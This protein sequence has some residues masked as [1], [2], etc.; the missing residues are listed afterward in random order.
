MWVIRCF[1]TRLPCVILLVIALSVSVGL[2]AGPPA[3]STEKDVRMAERWDCLAA[4]VGEKL[5][6]SARAYVRPRDPKV[7]EPAELIVSI[8]NLTDRVV[9]IPS[10]FED[11]V[12]RSGNG[13]FVPFTESGD[14][15]LHPTIVTMLPTATLARPG[16]AAIIRVPITKYFDLSHPGTY[17]LLAG[18]WM[19]VPN[20]QSR[21]VAAPRVDFTVRMDA[22]AERVK[23]RSDGAV[24]SGEYPK[25]G[26]F[27]ARWDFGVA[28]AQQGHDGINIQAT[29][30]PVCTRGDG[31]VVSLV[32]VPP[33]R[34]TAGDQGDIMPTTGMAARD[35]QILLRDEAERPVG[36]PKT[37]TPDDR[38]TLRRA[39]RPGE[40]AG[41]AFR[42][43]EMFEL[44]PGKNYRAIVVLPGSTKSEPTLAAGPIGFRACE[45]E[46]P[47]V[48]R[49]HFG[50]SRIWERFQRMGQNHA[51]AASVVLSWDKWEELVSLKVSARGLSDETRTWLEDVPELGKLVVLAC[52]DDR[53]LSSA[54][55]QVD[56]RYARWHRHSNKL[57]ADVDAGGE[58]DSSITAEFP[59]ALCYPLR[60]GRRFTV[61]CAVNLKGDLNRV[62]PSRPMTF[63]I[64]PDQNIVVEDSRP[65]L[66][67]PV[68]FG[69]R[70][71]ELMRFAGRAFEGLQL[72]VDADDPGRAGS[73]A[74][75]L[76]AHLR[77]RCPATLLIRK[78]RGDS[79]YEVLVRDPTGRPVSMTEKGRHFFD[80]GTML[81]VQGL[82]PGESI[83]ATL[84]LDELFEMKTPGEYTILASLP[85]I[86]DVD[87]V[88]TA[89]P[90]TIRI[91]GTP[92]G[93]KE[94]P[95]N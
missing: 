9:I 80:S 16:C 20:S 76:R 19:A 32:N 75:T 86:G 49:P 47:G 90:I 33:P 1:R 65:G 83:D 70:W 81:D 59:V 84:R 61:M 30:S 56:W 10:R 95:T 93:P 85:V 63:S 48:T 35:Y 39:L 64:T 22:E 44:I 24:A 26:S 14:A 57:S 71:D 7:G 50:S 42:L 46:I 88:L 52:E 5:G 58:L 51:T 78:W 54:N 45:P 29:M 55:S 43:D 67:K 6:V 73:G 37:P 17:T 3:T 25:L 13:E 21:L 66:P 53:I 36:R 79:D 92:A 27:D 23:H 12:I 69:T 77:S 34:L 38:V 41:F 68:P 40:A 82:G 2:A 4:R 8:C 15:R 87:A 89:A 62:V 60:P 72:D 31:L 74:I 18:H 28:A 94:S 11:V 91:G